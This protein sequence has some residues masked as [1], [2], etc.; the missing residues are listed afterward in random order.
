[1][2]IPPSTITSRSTGGGGSTPSIATGAFVCLLDRAH[3]RK[4]DVVEA[5]GMRWQLTKK[6]EEMLKM[7]RALKAR[8]CDIGTMKVSKNETK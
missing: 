5:E 3:A 7:Q 8:E 4:K 2:E 6:D 1:M